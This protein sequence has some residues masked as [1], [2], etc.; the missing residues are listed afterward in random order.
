V[1]L[2]IDIHPRLGLRLDAGPKGSVGP[3]LKD[4]SRSKAERGPNA[5]YP[6]ISWISQMK[7][8]VI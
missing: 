1:S 7:V 6:Q 2:Q 3:H 8:F 4:L 5:Q